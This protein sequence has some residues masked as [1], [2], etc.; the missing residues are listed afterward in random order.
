MRDKL[1]RAYAEALAHAGKG[2]VDAART[3]LKTHADLK[4]EIEKPENRSFRLQHEVQDAEIRAAFAALR[5]ERLE[6]IGLLTAAAPREIEL[7]QQFDDPPFYPNILWTKLGELYLATDSPKLAEA[8]FTRALAA[9]PNEPFALAGLAEARHKLGDET[10]A[11]EASARLRFVWSD[12]EPGNRRL[13]RI[14]ALNLRGEPIDRSPAPQRNYRKASLDRF[15]PAIWQPN[16]APGSGLA[17]PHGLHVAGDRGWFGISVG[18]C[19]TARPFAARA[20]PGV[21]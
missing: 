5:G 19:R 21:R 9:V 11:A 20:R 18:G 4:S 12:A 15:G 8:A 7:R 6:A 2:S 16:A 17:A 13:D 10:G 3:A 1:S 14:K